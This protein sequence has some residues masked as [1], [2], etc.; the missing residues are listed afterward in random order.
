MPNAYIA[1]TE[2]GAYG[3]VGTPQIYID[4]ASSL[5][6]AFLQRPEGLTYT[7]DAAGWPCYMTRLTPRLTL[8]IA[9][10]IVA[11]AMVTVALT[12]NID[13]N[14]DQLAGEVI[15]LDRGDD[16]LVEACV[17]NTATN[18]SITLANV[19]F[20]HPGPVTAD[21][22]LVITEQ[23]TMPQGRSVAHLSAWPIARIHSAVGRYGSPRQ[24]GDPYGYGQ[25]QGLLTIF[26]AFGGAPLWQQI[27]VSSMSWDAQTGHC[28]LPA[29]MW[30][31]YFN[32]VNV[33][34][35]S[36]WTQ[37]NVPEQIKS[38]VAQ[39]ATGIQNN[40]LPGNILSYKAGDTQIVRGV[41]TILDSDTMKIVRAFKSFQFA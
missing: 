18:T 10:P 27:A 4:R 23:K 5:I 20:T 41:A 28:W 38:A 2:L 40:L 15:V 1:A 21:F 24:G 19:L 3:V 14:P 30:L 34:Y 31:A 22:G 12:G 9:G 11:G 39:L 13:N 37:A 17:I 26:R 32:E 7:P 25:D 35:V 29:G 36:G 6:D 16:S 33:R 8:T